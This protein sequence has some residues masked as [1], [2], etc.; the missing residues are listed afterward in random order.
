M[1]LL[2][3]QGVSRI[4]PRDGGD[5]RALNAV[6]LAIDRGEFVAVT[7]RSGSGK[8][9]LLHVLGLLDTPT[10]GRYELAGVDVSALGDIERARL[11]N[12]KIGLVFQAFQLVPH[13]TVAENVELPL[14]YGGLDAP[15][16]IARY[17]AALERVGL[18]HR[19][20]HLPD[21][22]SGGE[23]QRT[24]IA[25]A[26]VADPD[27][28]LADEPTGNLDEAATSGVLDVFRDAHR[29]GTTVVVV[30]HNERVAARA[31]RRYEM[32]AGRLRAAEAV[33]VDPAGS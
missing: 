5:V 28:L 8:S 12:R 10:A 33:A 16:R 6:E 19:L 13:L 7:G 24:A 31:D 4:Y 1:P 30:T 32:A 29:A 22:L 26:L 2:S 17:R 27:V 3:L 20:T 11:R 18:A 14:V 21:E 23:Q 9:T 25:R 15:L